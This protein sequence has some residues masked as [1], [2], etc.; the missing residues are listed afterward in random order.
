MTE[1]A[2][3]NPTPTVESQS[4]NESETFAFQAE[5]S[6]LMSLI[7][8]TFYSNKDIFL[9]ELIS[10]SSDA[11]DKIRYESLS[12]KSK[13]ESNPE[14]NIEIYPNSEDN[15]LTIIDSGVGM[16]KADLINNL[17]TIAKSGTKAFMEALSSGADVSLIGQFGVG[18]YSAFLVADRVDVTTKHN[19]DEA[20]TWSSSANGSFTI[21][22]TPDSNLK[23]GTQIRLHI[24]EDQR[25]YLEEHKIREIITKHSEF[26]NYPITLQ[27][28][29]E[30]EL[31]VTDD[32]EEPNTE[33]TKEE[34]TKEEDENT[35]PTI[36]E[37]PDDEDGAEKSEPKKKTRKIKEKYQEMDLLNKNKPLWTRKQEDVTN[38]EYANF[39]KSISNDWE[40]HLTVK[41]FSAEG[42]IEFKSLLFIPKRA[43]FDMFNN[44]NTK[45]KIKLYVRRVFIMDNCP[46][47]LPDYLGFIPGIVDSEDLPL[48]I[49][50][51]ILQQSKI[52][53]SIKKTLTKKCIEMMTDLMED[54]EKYTTFYENFSRNIKLGIHEDST[55]RDK[56]TKLLRYHSSTQ[57]EQTSLEDYVTRM[58]EKQS[59]IY[60]ITGE[61]L[62]VV[63]S[64]PYVE[65]LNK[66]GYEVLYMVEPIDEYCVGQLNEFDGHKLVCI[67]KEDFKL[68][69][70]HDDFETLKAEYEPLANHIK[71]TMGD[72]LEKVIITN[73]L[74][75]SPCCISTGSFG[76]SANMERIMKAQALNSNSMSSHMTPKKYL[77]LNPYHK[78][79]QSM[80]SKFEND[81]KENLNNL[82]SLMFDMALI[83]GGFALDNPRQLSE[84]V[85]NIVS[86]G[87]GIDYDETEDST[88][89]K[90]QESLDN[91]NTDEN[92]TLNVEDKTTESTNNEE[93]EEMESV[94]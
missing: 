73:R 61:N 52:L 2:N 59:D 64:S 8:N 3:S 15:T 54:S 65:G 7:I 14:L 80:K 69:G 74:T 33:E 37:V 13:L 78:I 72:R 18:F 44:A 32:E 11:I 79:V 40:E 70:E 86:L 87:L 76:W 53:N 68:P 6:Q 67:T 30:R 60:Y 89:T 35:E 82:A 4:S 23:R 12:D 24:K 36:E 77:E 49:S 71:E 46:D 84:K 28:N 42:Q 31:E 50:R 34:E 62:D 48:N 51:E 66:H 43:P 56:L 29:K 19:D 85:Y 25:E 90:V 47:I 83:D 57:E 58:P 55:N 17:G 5:I 20:Y 75:D 88:D 63:S 45:N 94:D 26:I 41:H 81:E 1:V 22:P 10:N 91:S 93:N 16:T 27:V 9:R 39:Y 92:L 21:N 38:D